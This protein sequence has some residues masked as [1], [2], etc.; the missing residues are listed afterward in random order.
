MGQWISRTL[1]L[2]VGMLH[3]ELGTLILKLQMWDFHRRGT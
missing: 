3:Q 2:K 1:H